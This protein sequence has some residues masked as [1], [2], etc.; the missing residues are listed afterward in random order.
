MSTWF[1][2]FRL[3]LETKEV[4]ILYGNVRDKYIT[5]ND[6]ASIV[7]ESLA[8]AIDRLISEATFPTRFQPDRRIV[9]DALGVERQLGRSLSN[10]SA[11]TSTPFPS[12]DRNISIPDEDMKPPTRVL[13]KWKQELSR[14]GNPML[15]IIFYLDKLI[16]YKENYSSGKD[17]ETE[18][19]LWLE[20]VIQTI[21][22]DNRLILVALEDGMIPREL[23]TFS[24]KVRLVDVPMPSQEDRKRYVTE[25]LRH[26]NLKYPDSYI[27]LIAD[28][29]DGL[30][31]VDLDRIAGQPEIT[32]AVPPSEHEMR[33]LINRYRVG[34]KQDYWG[35]LEVQRLESIPTI[36]VE[37]Y[38]VKG[39][40]EAIERV[41]DM[42]LVAKAGLTSIASDSDTA[43]K[44]KGMLFFVGPSGVGKT[45]L[46]K[47]I[48]HFLFNSEEAF[49]RF[50]MS[51]FKE[52]HAISKLIGSPP[53][54]VGYDRGGMLTDAVRKKPFSVVLFDEIEKA[55]PKILDI[56]LQ[57]IDDGRLTDSRGQT[58]FFTESIIIFTSNVGTRTEDKDGKKINERE[59]FDQVKSERDVDAERKRERVRQHFINA[60]DRF[61][62]K[63][64]SRPEL[65]NRIGSNIVPFNRIDD[66]EIQR[67][68]VKRHLQNISTRY[69]EIHRSDGL[70]VSF[71][72]ESI[73]DHIVTSYKERIAEFGGRA[74]YDII[75]SQI[76]PKLASRTLQAAES[77][78]KQNFRV[79]AEDGKFKIPLVK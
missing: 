27:K 77:M 25:R 52:E 62:K 20:K 70:Q 1:N 37:E 35:Q 34:E 18:I 32:P 2:N 71:D 75:Q 28:L 58:V 73:A 68:I 33:R 44:P 29:T 67:D 78:T 14:Q 7:H 10:A 23:Y 3:A 6:G 63:E 26:R 79:R 4:V 43:G 8:Q 60:V 64:I 72:E 42:L 40:D 39:Q 21:T 51:E 55:H 76:I 74:V 50:D 59:L 56:F 66:E 57:L 38:G 61:F 69:N 47:K 54:Y 41:R 31:L 45:F 22:P 19:L 24:P 17:S 46:A 30:Y 53:G 49:V 9:Y 13:A 36:F 5:Y 65:L 16:A 12:Q 11:T 15:A 48:A